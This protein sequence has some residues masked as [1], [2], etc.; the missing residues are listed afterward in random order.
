MV[1]ELPLEIAVSTCSNSFFSF[2]CEMVCRASRSAAVSGVP[3]LSSRARLC[4][5]D[6]KFLITIISPTY[7][8]N[9][10]YLFNSVRARR[11]VPTK[12][13]GREV[14]CVVKNSLIESMI[15]VL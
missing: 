5:K 13:R 11:N 7:G 9:M 8:R 3:D 4:V 2:G 6:K 15:F 1:R 10:A 14:R 12:I